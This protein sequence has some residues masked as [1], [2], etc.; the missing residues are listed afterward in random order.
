MHN[1]GNDILLLDI[2]ELKTNCIAAGIGILF[3]YILN[4]SFKEH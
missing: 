3:N 2:A 1:K 4:M